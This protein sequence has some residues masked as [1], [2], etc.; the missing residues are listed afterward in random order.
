MLKAHVLTIV[1]YLTHKHFSIL[2]KYG[3]CVYHIILLHSLQTTVLHINH[4]HEKVQL[5]VQM[6]DAIL[7]SQRWTICATF[8]EQFCKLKVAEYRIKQRSYAS[9][10]TISFFFILENMNSL[11]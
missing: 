9:T 4:F 1:V 11:Q 2:F 3:S 5:T 10:S 7:E 6:I 8:V